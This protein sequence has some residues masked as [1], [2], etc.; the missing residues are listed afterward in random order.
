MVVM[1]NEMLRRG[2]IKVNGFSLLQWTFHDRLVIIYN[3]FS[4]RVFRKAGG[5]PQ[6]MKKHNKYNKSVYRSFA[7]IA[8]FGIHM[9]VPIFACFLLGFYLDKKLGTS[10]LTILFFFIGALAGFRNVY[11]LARRIYKDRD[12]GEQRNDK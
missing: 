8:Q 6:F 12:S 5:G 3:R 2:E 1:L 7:V 10:Y 11:R 4:Y 9:L